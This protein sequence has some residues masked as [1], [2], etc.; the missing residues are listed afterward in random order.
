MTSSLNNGKTV[1]L[2]LAC[3][4]T[5]AAVDAAES[6]LWS[7]ERLNAS[8]SDWHLLNSVDLR[9]EGRVASQIKNQIRFRNCSLSFVL[10]PELERRAGQS[11]T[12]EVTGRIERDGG[13]LVFRVRDLRATPTDLETLRS[14][15]VALRNP[16]P[17]DWYQLAKWARERG[18]F[19]QDEELKEAGLGYVA[20][21]IAAEQARLGQDDVQ[22]RFTLADKAD[23]LGLPQLV[24]DNLRH[25]AFRHWWLQAGS[26]TK[27]D[28]PE[29]TKLEKRLGEVWPDALQPGTA[30]PSEVEQ[31]YSEFPL[32]TYRDADA[33]R[34]QILRRLL[35]ADVQLLRLTAPA[36][37]DGR[38]GRKVADEILAKVPERAKTA[39]RFRDAELMY[40]VGEIATRSKADAVQIAD[41][42]RA[43]QRPAEATEALLRWVIAKEQR[44]RPQT[45]PEFIELADDYL[46]LLKDKQRAVALLSEAHKLEPESVDVQQRFAQLGYVF[47]GITW[48]QPKE[49]PLPSADPRRPETISPLTAGMTSGELTRMLGLPT[50]RSRSHT[51]KGL[52]EYWIYG[53][54]GEASRL[55]VELHRGKSAAELLVTRFYHR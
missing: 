28:L 25:E 37:K 52:D 31:A 6:V 17:D 34:R 50:S 8:K 15:E 45:A 5:S 2:L 51:A 32:E 23:R 54:T 43:R 10:P 41:E 53:Q 20:R 22:G 16:G 4:L 21:G 33:S 29:L 9:V 26:V 46:S 12:L 3:V 30:F 13:N 40:R 48:T 44:V 27:P 49:M 19:Y 18:V 11:K 47:N 7:I 35:A 55:V 24:G 38:D 14:K 1:C 39:Q 42:L 36:A